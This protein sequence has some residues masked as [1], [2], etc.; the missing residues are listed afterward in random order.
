ML[1]L[2][3]QRL[4]K[5]FKTPQT[6]FKTL[7]VHNITIFL[8]SSFLFFFVV[9]LLKSQHSG[10]Y[11][12]RT[13]GRRWD[14]TVQTGT[15]SS[16]IDTPIFPLTFNVLHSQGWQCDQKVKVVLRSVPDPNVSSPVY[17]GTEKCGSF[18]S[19]LTG[20]ASSDHQLFVGGKAVNLNRT[21]ERCEAAH[22]ML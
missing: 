6:L 4:M 13:P 12:A 7:N 5:P 20:Q 14:H 17:T 18:N 15:N 3:P 10:G 8:S 16:I 21:A 22:R 2:Q 1:N 11:K 9:L 19:T